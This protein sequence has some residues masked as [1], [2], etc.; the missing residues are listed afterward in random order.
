MKLKEYLAVLIVF[1]FVALTATTV[2]ATL[3]NT[4]NFIWTDP[5][6]QGQIQVTED[7]F[8]NYLGDFSIYEWRYTINN[9][10]YDPF[11]GQSNGLSGFNLV[12]PQAIPE[13]ANQY[14]PVGWF[15]NCCGTT[16]PF[17]AEFDINNAAGFGIPI[18]GSGIFG[19]TTDPRW[20]VINSIGD[21]TPDSWMHSWVSNSQT[22]TFSGPISVPGNPIPE[23][24]T[25]LLLG[26]GLLG[27]VFLRRKFGK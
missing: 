14:A 5:S 16:P 4:H 19:F 26:G 17:G 11:P 18:G 15:F 23:P 10:S 12:F 13:L 20:D 8:D 27:L 3:I 6:S 1:V 7:V 22:I 2:Q 9:I 21:A 25:M 24:S